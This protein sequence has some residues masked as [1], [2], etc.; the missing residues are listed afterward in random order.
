MSDRLNDFDDV[1]AR[2]F[3][4]LAEASMLRET[5]RLQGATRRDLV[6]SLME[7][8]MIS[9]ERRMQIRNALQASKT[10]RESFCAPGV[11]LPG[12]L[13][14]GA[15]SVTA[16]T[17]PLAESG[18]GVGSVIILLVEDEVWIRIDLADQLREAGYTVY[19]A[20]TGDAAIELLQSPFKID[21]V[22]TDVRMPGRTD[23]IALA[24]YI[25]EKR[26]GIKVVVMSGDYR[27]PPEEKQLFDAFQPKPFLPE[28]MAKTIQNLMMEPGIAQTDPFDGESSETE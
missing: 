11:L 19:E 25:R 5:L 26:P 7:Q 23:G 8:R 4:A 6:A 16:E 15:G 21:L 14:V 28:V 20:A 12:R 17:G 27:P 13:S 18:L 10:N 24:A 22:V 2:L 1:R 3:H 9:A